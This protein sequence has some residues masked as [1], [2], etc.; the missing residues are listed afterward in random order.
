MEPN[1]GTVL[2]NRKWQLRW[3]HILLA[4]F[5]VVLIVIA[6][7][8][9]HQIKTADK[10]SQTSVN[11]GTHA[12]TGNGKK[13]PSS[14]KKTSVASG[15]KSSSSSKKSSTKASSNAST[16]TMPKT[17]TTN[18][19]NSTSTANNGTT[20]SSGSPALANTGPGDTIALFAGVTAV[21]TVGHYLYTKR[22][23]GLSK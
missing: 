16:T 18:T 21:G 3:G 9:I 11:S 13:K 5:F 22:R 15:S 4:L 14:S 23:L 1:N 7:I 10:T 6:Y 12:T 2:A 19:N 8:V 20:K 17:T